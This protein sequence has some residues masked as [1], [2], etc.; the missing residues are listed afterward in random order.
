M[1]VGFISLGCSK[2]LID[3][4][5]IIGKFK[6]NDYKIVNN[7]EEADIIVVNTCGFIESAKQEAIDTIFEMLEYKKQR[8]KYLVVTGCL[9][10]RY[11]DDLV[12]ALPEVDL[13]IRI[14]EYKDFW[15]K[16]DSIV[17]DNKTEI[18]KFNKVTKVSQIEQI[19]LL[20]QDEFENRVITTGKNYAYLKIGEGCSNMCTYCAI[21]YIRGKF[22]SR[23]IEDVVIEAKVLAKQGI[24]E[25]IVIA[26]DTTKYGVDIYGKS[27][28]T[29]V[30]REVSK[31]EGIEWIRFLYS[32]PEGITDELIN[33]VKTNKKICKYF[34]IPIQHISDSVLKGMN[35]KTSKK[36]IENLIKKIRKEIPNITLRTS[37]IV[38]FPG[39]TKEQFE[40][41]AL[42]T[43]QAK[44]DKLGAFMYSKE[45]G[46]PA[47]RMKNQ[48]HGNTKKSRFN[49]IMSI[50]KEISKQ[51]LENKIGTVTKVLVENISFDGKFLIGRTSQDVPEIDGLVYIKNFENPQKLL[52]EFVDVKIVSVEDYD[53]VGEIV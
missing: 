19:P 11:Y 38:G 49:K 23:K 6:N 8:C 3:T 51:K 40:E 13:F 43:K 18:T 28:L 48:I 44:F 50:Q 32:Y 53:L 35:R 20:E 30:L 4:E 29:E 25:L 47:A 26:Q 7:P 45:D 42:F 37:L 46:T 2:N 1:N 22:V 10:Q 39:E 14:D 21:P 16:I 27:M 5:I 31:I 36:D 34:D 24:K 41:L 17:V 33:E 52:N 9:V 12:K 15:D